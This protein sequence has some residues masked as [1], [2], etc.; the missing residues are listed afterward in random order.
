MTCWDMLYTPFSSEPW[1]T[2]WMQVK[3]SDAKLT[4]VRVQTW[5]TPFLNKIWAQKR[6]QSL[7]LTY[8]ALLFEPNCLWKGFICS[9]HLALHNLLPCDDSLLIFCC[10][11]SVVILNSHRPT[12]FSRTKRQNHHLRLCEHHPTRT[13]RVTP[14]NG[15]T[16]SPGMCQTS[17][18]EATNP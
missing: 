3:G 5:W 10:W 12:R 7:Q 9:M 2:L 17:N 14:R 8:S 11:S 16:T 13:C 4:E 1:Q 15:R 18:F 6:K